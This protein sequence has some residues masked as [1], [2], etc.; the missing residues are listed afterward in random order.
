MRLHTSLLPLIS[1][2][3]GQTFAQY[4]VPVDKPVITTGFQ[5]N[6]FDYDLD[7][8]LYS[9]APKSWTITPWQN[10]SI[11]PQACHNSAYKN[12]VA[13]VNIDVANIRFPDCS[14]DWTV[15]RTQGVGI[16]WDDMAKVWLRHEHLSSM[17]LTRLAESSHN[18]TGNAS[19]Y[20]QYSPCSHH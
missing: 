7:R 4:G 2:F 16:T 1:A 17:R 11:I 3:L 20:I 6:D 19:I 10:T 9:S 14:K 12:G 18:S 13:S 15:C 5:Y 8:L